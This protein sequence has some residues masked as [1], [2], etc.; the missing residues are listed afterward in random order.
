MPNFSRTHRRP[1]LTPALRTREFADIKLMRLVV[2]AVGIPE[3]CHRAACRRARRCASPTVGCF[4]ENIEAVREFAE[5]LAAWS[6]LDGPRD[7]E[8]LA[9]PV[10][11]LF[12]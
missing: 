3:N 1:M 5:G 11:A 8:E 7:P 10:T 9:R 6:R 12:D 4:D 2:A